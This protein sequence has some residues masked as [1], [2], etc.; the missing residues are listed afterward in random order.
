MLKRTTALATVLLS[1]LVS[2]GARAADGEELLLGKWL[3][4]ND[5]SVVEISRCGD[6]FCGRIISLREPT[7]AAKDPEA[8]KPQHDRE[9]PDKSLRAR[10]LVGLELLKGFTYSGDGEWE[11]GTIYDPANG[12]TYKCEIAAAEGGKKLKVRGFIGISLIG[13]TTLWRRAQ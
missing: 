3:T 13:R 5:D 7:Y 9:N 4:D 6:R 8:G 1:L 10:P 11:G 2:A 12:K